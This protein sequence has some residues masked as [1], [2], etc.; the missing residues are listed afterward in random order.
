M[1]SAKLKNT[2]IF[3]N[4]PDESFLEKDDYVLR[5]PYPVL[6]YLGRFQFKGDF[7]NVQ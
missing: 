2:F 4:I 1:K 7:E 6:T 5:L 3:P